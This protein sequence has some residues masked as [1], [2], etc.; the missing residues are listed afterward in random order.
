MHLLNTKYYFLGYNCKVKDSTH[1]FRD[2]TESN[3]IRLFFLYKLIA[4]FIFDFHAANG[5]NARNDVADEVSPNACQGNPFFLK[6]KKINK[7]LF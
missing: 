2:D 3:Q 5:D 7:S 6:K 4:Y 1:D